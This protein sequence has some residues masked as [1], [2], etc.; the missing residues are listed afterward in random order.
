MRVLVV[1]AL[2]VASACSGGGASAPGTQP[3]GTAPPA[4]KAVWPLRG[5]DA[6]SADAAKRRPIVFRVPNDP[7]ARPQAGL[8]SADVVFEML[9]EG[10][11]TRYA[12]VFHSQDADKVGPIRSARLSDLHYTPMLRGILAHVGAQSTVLQRIRDAAKGGRFVDVDQFE[13]AGAF[14]RVSERAAPQNVYTSTKRIREAAKDD[15]KVDVPPLAFG[16]ATGGTA[17]TSFVVPYSGTTRVEYTPQA[18]GF[19]RAQGGQPTI[20]DATKQ[21]VLPV[22]V[23]VIKTDITEVP[24]I[25]EDE[26]GSLSLEIRSTGT[27]PAVVLTDGKRFDGTWERSGDGNYAFKEAS[28]GA[29]A[30]RP[31]LTWIHVV[32]LSFD[33]GK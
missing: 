14:D 5:T 32:P 9:V 18:S 22:N 20:D 4:A 1:T 10:G 27:G 8:G 21:E 6:P 28:G 29:I 16:G 15:S 30:L 33:L 25:V 23:V 7:A 17:V 12:V 31:G 13:H 19:K 11:I 2:L 24:G 26:Q 3:A